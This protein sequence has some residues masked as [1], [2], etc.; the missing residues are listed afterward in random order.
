MQPSCSHSSSLTEPPKVSLVIP[1]FNRADLLVETVQSALDQT[2]A[3]HE[4]IVV[5]DGSVDA[6]QDRLRNFGSDIVSICTPNCGVQAARNTGVKASTAPWVAFCD[7]DDLLEPFFLEEVQSFLSGPKATAG[8]PMIDAIYC[9]FKII[10]MAG[11]DRLKLA[12]APA[13]FLTGATLTGDWVY[14]IPQVYERL[15]SFQPFFPSGMVIH[16]DFFNRI[17]GYDIKLRGIPG[18]DFEFTLRVAA[19]GTIAYSTKALSR[20][21]KHDGNDS[22]NNAKVNWGDAR[23]LLHAIKAHERSEAC[24]V[25]MLA[26]AHARLGM[27]YDGHFVQRDFEAMR[28]IQRDLPPTGWPAKRRLK[29]LIASLPEPLRTALW[30][31]SQ[32]I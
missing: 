15:L 7:S 19:R 18:E 4:I 27:A 16:K 8:S 26:S 28:S 21:R 11:G 23:L 10:G 2:R 17:G 1:T 3:F 9:N 13:E 29:Q 12:S 32:A 30:R 14:D 24:Q 6:T 25:L 20:V 22:A 5:D 31:G